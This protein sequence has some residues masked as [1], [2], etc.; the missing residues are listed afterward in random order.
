MK[1]IQKNKGKKLMLLLQVAAF[2]VHLIARGRSPGWK[3]ES[4]KAMR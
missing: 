1:E 3:L 2:A 4:M